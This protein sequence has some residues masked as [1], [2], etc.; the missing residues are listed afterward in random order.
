MRRS[1]ALLVLAIAA[2][3]FG[4]G[5][6][7]AVTPQQQINQLKRQVAR[8]QDQMRAVQHE[9][10]CYDTLWPFSQFGDSNSTF[11]YLWGQTDG[12]VFPTTALDLADPNQGVADRD[13]SW[14]VSYN[15]DCAEAALGKTK[16]VAR[17]SMTAANKVAPKVSAGFRWHW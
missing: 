13:F 15:A 14:F 12:T 17:A 4:V 2:S 1:A 10:A 7:G 11:G 3:L 8:L 5:A 6:A 16:R 9:Q